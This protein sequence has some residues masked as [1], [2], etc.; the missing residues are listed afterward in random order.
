MGLFN[1]WKELII[2]QNSVTFAD[3]CAIL[4]KSGIAYKEKTQNI[5]HGNRR[6]GLTGSLGE[7]PSYSYLYQIFVK[8]DDFDHAKSLIAHDR[9]C[10]LKDG[11]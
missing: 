8:Q 4:K 7:N 1:K 9:H 6:T 5:G 10:A 11:M 3:V 2:T